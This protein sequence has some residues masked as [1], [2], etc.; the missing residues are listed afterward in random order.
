MASKRVKIKYGD[1]TKYQ[2]LIANYND[3]LTSSLKNLSLQEDFMNDN[4][5]SIIQTV[6]NIESHTIIPNENVFM[7][8][9]SNILA[10]MYSTTPK[11]EFVPKS[12]FV[13]VKF[14]EDKEISNNDKVV[15]ENKHND[16]NDKKDNN[17]NKKEEVENKNK[18]DNLMNKP[19]VNDRNNLIGNDDKIKNNDIIKNDKIDDFMNKNN[20]N[21][22]N[23]DVNYGTIPNNIKEIL[24]NKDTKDNNNNTMNFNKKDELRKIL[25]SKKQQKINENIQNNNNSNNNISQVQFE[26]DKIKKLLQKE[27][28]SIEDSIFSKISNVLN[29]SS[30]SRI[31]ESHGNI[32]N[33]NKTSRPI[34]GICSICKYPNI[35]DFVYYCTNENCNGE[36]ICANCED[37][38][39]PEDSDHT[40]VKS[41]KSLNFK[42]KTLID[43]NFS[44]N[45]N[46]SYMTS[47]KAFTVYEGKN[48]DIYVDIKNIGKLAWTKNFEIYPSKE[49]DVL[50]KNLILK[51][52]FAPNSIFNAELKLNTSD[53]KKGI[54]Y[55]IWKMKTNKGEEFENKIQIMIEVI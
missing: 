54:Y 38:H 27:L 49:S 5:L 43:K 53:L 37:E 35:Y 1:V 4:F 15:N 45:Y 7:K 33:L 24:K 34:V 42:Q 26:E 50:G 30:I 21:D 3:F 13:D 28:K 10:N 39:F 44:E 31:N 19:N 29:S 32:S 25:E 47:Q 18:N 41:Y 51:N 48:I 9:Y 46:F 36:M 55:T 20:Y 2:Q 52:N 22:Q 40:L 14:V 8:I 17:L 16:N 6:N 11:F 23:D 12:N